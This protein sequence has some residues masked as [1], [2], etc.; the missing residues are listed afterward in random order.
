[1]KMKRIFEDR[2]LSRRWSLG[3]V[4]TLVL[5][6][7]VGAAVVGRASAGGEVIGK[8]KQQ[9]HQTAQSGVDAYAFVVPGE[10][11]L[12]VNPVLVTSRS[13]NIE[14]VTSPAVGVYCLKPAA[15]IDASTRS[16]SVTPEASRST[17]S[18]RQVFAYTDA[19][20]ATCPAGQFAVRTYELNINGVAPMPMPSEH[21]AFMVVIP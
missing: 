20:P 19:D 15:S 13:R 5:V 1:M 3:V 12:N 10:V 9:R 2:R 4:V 7:A 16:W 14:A 11:S 18:F 6:A 8:A 17:S 21:V